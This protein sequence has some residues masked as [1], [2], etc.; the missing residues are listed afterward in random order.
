MKGIAKDKR[1]D[2][3]IGDEKSI[4][5]DTIRIEKAQQKF[6]EKDFK[7]SIALYK[8]VEHIDLFTDLDK[9]IIAYCERHISVTPPTINKAEQ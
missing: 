5:D 4:K 1:A 8:A 6:Y 9:K 2:K 7:E 3:K